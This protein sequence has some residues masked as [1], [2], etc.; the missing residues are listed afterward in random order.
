MMR[1][2][3]LGARLYDRL[4]RERSSAELTEE[5][6]YHR[7]LLERDRASGCGMGNATYYR[8]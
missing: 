2:R 6:Q 8:E 5:L 4:H 3:E 1:L 7:T